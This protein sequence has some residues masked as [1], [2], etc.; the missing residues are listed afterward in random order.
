MVQPIPVVFVAGTDGVPKECGLAGS[1]RSSQQDTRIPLIM[2]RQG[3]KTVAKMSRIERTNFDAVIKRRDD[4]RCELAFCVAA[5]VG[6]PPTPIP[7]QLVELLDEHVRLFVVRRVQPPPN[8]EAGLAPGYR[9]LGVTKRDAPARPAGSRFGRSIGVH[10]NLQNG[11]CSALFR[12]F[13]DTDHG[14]HAIGTTQNNIFSPARGRCGRRFD[15]VQPI[16]L[17][18]RALHAD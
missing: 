6:A 14:C 13:T 4:L 5:P 7:K 1:G 8:L 11:R 10:P 17:F 9:A 15:D 2:R 18:F 12:P 3:N 16:R